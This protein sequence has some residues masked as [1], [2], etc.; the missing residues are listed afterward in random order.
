MRCA[1][2]RYLIQTFPRVSCNCISINHISAIFHVV[3]YVQVE[4]A[5][6]ISRVEGQA[7]ELEFFQ[8]YMASSLAQSS[9]Q[10]NALKKDV[11]HYKFLAEQYGGSGGGNA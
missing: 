9:N 3:G 1:S 2:L 6:L 5:A 10:I 8:E 4:R 11:T 7:A